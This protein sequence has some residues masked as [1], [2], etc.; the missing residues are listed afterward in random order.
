MA[1]CANCG[2]DVQ[3]RFCAKCGT[4]VAAG[5]AGPPP[6]QPGPNP[7][8]PPPPQNPYPPQ[9]QYG[10]PAAQAGLEENMACALCYLLGVLTGVLFLVLEPYNKNRNIRFHAFQSIFTWLAMI[11][12]WIAFLIVSSIIT[13]IPFIGWTVSVLLWLFGLGMFALWLVLMY[14]AYNRERW[15]LPIIG[16]LAEKQV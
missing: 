13:M 12:V 4:P 16:P 9:S 15:V 2:S 1:F 5:P 6:P 3:G 10:A 8:T 11:V 14:K 7:Y